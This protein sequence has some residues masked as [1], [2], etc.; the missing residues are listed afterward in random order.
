MHTLSPQ[1]FLRSASIAAHHYGFTPVERLKE[2]PLCKNCTEKVAYKTSASERRS[3]ALHGMLT[4]GIC[5]FFDHKLH[6]IDGPTLFYSVEQMPRTGE[7][8]IVFQIFN[9][10]SYSRTI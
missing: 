9:V 6:A 8:A 1:D 4:G 2:N 5:T 10:K 3:D 7:M